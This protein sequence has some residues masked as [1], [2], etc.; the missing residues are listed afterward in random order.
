[1]SYYKGRNNTTPCRYFQQGTCNK[2]NNCKF[3]HVYQNDNGLNNNQSRYDN[4]S[5]NENTSEKSDVQKLNNFITPPYLNSI[6]KTISFDMNDAKNFQVKPLASSYSYELPCALNLIDGRDLSLEESRFQYYQARQNGTLNQYEVEMNAREKD[7]QKCFAHIGGHTDWAAR[8]LQKSTE[9]ITQ[10]GKLSYENPFINF[11]VDLTGQSYANNHTMTETFGSGLSASA[12]LPF[13]TDN[14]ANTSAF[15]SNTNNALGNSNFG[16]PN[17]AT[18]SAFVAPEFKASSG[19]IFGSSSNLNPPQSGSSAF[20]TPA[21]GAK[22]TGSSAFG[23]PSFGANSFGQN[24]FGSTSQPSG[25]TGSPFGSLG[26][27]QNSTTS[28]TESPFGKPAFGAPVASAT[29]AFGTPAFGSSSFGAAQNNGKQ[30]VAAS[31]FGSFQGDPSAGNTSLTFGSNGLGASANNSNTAGHNSSPFGFVAQGA[32][33]NQPASNVFGGTLSNTTNNAFGTSS[34]GA[35]GGKTSSPFGSASTQ[36][37]ISSPFGSMGSKP[38]AGFGVS[39]TQQSSPFDIS[40]ASQNYSTFQ[41]SF[42]QG[43]PTED[44]LRKPEDLLE[45]TLQKFQ[46]QEFSLG[47]VPDIPPPLVLCV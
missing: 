39:T 4:N 33:N 31:P 5:N 8:Y 14:S 25:T 47:S 37:N 21:F 15:G 11:T 27:Q 24:P 41:N 32:A 10:K 1:M 35:F 3:A 20:G 13:R 36:G 40:Q 6:Q 22:N 42:V 16:N 46:G 34:T 38:S 43:P 19:S 12:N 7:M 44:D 2:G 26:N 9:D 45:E 28:N 18:T 17:I 29:S 30:E 23:A